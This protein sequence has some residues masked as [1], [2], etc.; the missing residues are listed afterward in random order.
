M[1]NKNLVIIVILIAI[2]LLFGKVVGSSGIGK[3]IVTVS[4]EPISFF[5]YE[6]GGPYVEINYIV[7]EEEEFHE[8]V[9]TS[10][11][12]SKVLSS[13][14]IIITGHIAWEEELLMLI[15]EEKE[16]EV[17]G[18]S[19]DLMGD[20][21]DQL[22]LMN[23]PGTNELNIH[24]YWLYLPNALV[25]AKSVADKLG[26]IDPIHRDFYLNSYQM[27]RERI[28]RLN[29][30]ILESIMDLGLYG[31]EVLAVTPPEQYILLSLGLNP[32]TILVH[33]ELYSVSPSIL[34]EARELLEK[35]KFEYIFIS[36]LTKKKPI[37][38]YIIEL[39]RETGV[40]IIE[41][42]TLSMDGLYF[43]ETLYTYNLGVIEGIGELEVNPSRDNWPE[44]VYIS[45][46]FVV[47]ILILGLVF[48]II[49]IMRG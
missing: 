37:F 2:L 30:T 38:E 39:S 40:P 41:L 27:F 18:F 34:Q 16:R 24:G 25:I 29:N 13:D 36:D 23:F 47:I 14:L 43:L 10:N 1:R 21:R 26:D 22:I 8:I 15:S 5:V 11:M 45:M 31:T 32:S 33:G 17:S 9:I 19:L 12:V 49:K 7:S 4:I 35:G 3:V 48:H 28:E 6:I 42:R 44:M 20:L 46:I